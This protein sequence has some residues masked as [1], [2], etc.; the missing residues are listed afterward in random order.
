MQTPWR[1][2]I[3]C[4]TRPSTNDAWFGVETLS[5]DSFDAEFEYTSQPFNADSRAYR[6]VITEV[7]P[8]GAPIIVEE[9]QD[10]GVT[11]GQNAVFTV[12][13]V[14]SEPLSYRWYFNDALLAGETQSTLIVTNAQS[15]DVGSYHVVVYGILGA[16]QSA[17]ATLTV[18][19][20]P[21]PALIEQPSSVSLLSGE[22]ATFSVT[23]FGAAPLSYQWYLNET[24]L[25]AGVNSSTLTVSNA[26]TADAGSYQVVVSN[27]FGL[28]TSS[29]QLLPCPT[30]CRS[31]CRIRSKHSRPWLVIP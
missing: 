4:S 15:G 29:W 27:S 3:R 10:V 22:D 1:S 25:I 18:V 6:V 21:S 14:S 9:P 12:S 19:T 30:P 20:D 24:N 13:A 26:Q 8:D 23:V 5:P 16:S 28:V 2:A 11:D 31:C 7:D 17:A